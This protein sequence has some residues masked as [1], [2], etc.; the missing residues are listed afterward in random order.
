MNK[1]SKNKKGFTLVEMLLALAIICLIGGVIAGIC[2]SI[3]N[4]FLTTYKIDDSA[5]Y[6]LLY[7]KGF[8]NSFLANTQGAGSSNDEWTWYV[9]QS[10]NISELKMEDPEDKINTVF[11]PQF[12]GG[13]SGG[14]KWDVYMFFKFDSDK[15][16]VNYRIFMKDNAVDTSFIYTYDGNFW[17]PRF[18]QRAD[19]A[20]VK[21]SRKISVSGVPMNGTTFKNYGFSTEELNSIAGQMDPEYKSVITYNWG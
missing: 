11:H 17:V 14:A 16:V 2:V 13:A 15:N 6:A 9:D 5:D 10:G 4:S 8:E 21:D 12:M 3:S 7:S 19:F 18:G 1:V 20:G